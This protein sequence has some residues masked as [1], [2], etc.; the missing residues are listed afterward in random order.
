AMR[1]DRVF[2]ILGGATVLISDVKITGGVTDDNGA[3]IESAGT[4]TLV[5]DAIVGNHAIGV[6]DGGAVDSGGP[7]LAITQSTLA[8]NVAY[9]G[10]ATHSGHLLTITR[11]PITGNSGGGPGENGDCGRIS[12]SAGSA[13]LINNSPI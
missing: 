5:R 10:G 2:E 9:N 6:A 11:S 8:G 4:L 12:G 3:G 1:I 7:A 13:G